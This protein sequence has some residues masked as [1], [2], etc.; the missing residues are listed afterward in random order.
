M[1]RCTCHTGNEHTVRVAIRKI[2]LDMVLANNK[3]RSFMSKESTARLKV[4]ETVIPFNRPEKDEIQYLAI[5]TS[6]YHVF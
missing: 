1:P 4:S 2:I 6:E 3:M 5:H